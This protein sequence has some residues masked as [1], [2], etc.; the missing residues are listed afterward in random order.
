MTICIAWRTN[1]KIKVISDSRYSYHGKYADIGAKIFEVP[2]NITFLHQSTD[3]P[4]TN[5]AYNIG[6]CFAGDVA[7]AVLIKDVF[8]GLL[9]KCQ[10]LDLYTTLHHSE[11]ANLLCNI[12]QYFC[13][14][15]FQGIQCSLDFSIY[16]IFTDIT[17]DNDI[18]YKIKKTLLSSQVKLSPILQ[19]DEQFDCEGSQTPVCQAYSDI[20]TYFQNN[21]IGNYPIHLLQMMIQTGNFPQ[22]GGAIQVGQIN[23]RN[24]E[25]IGAISINAANS[26]KV[27]HTVMGIDINDPEFTN[28]LSNYVYNGDFYE[29]K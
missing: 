24:F 5:Y 2:T 23:E 18:C 13:T 28:E 10:I 15:Y 16:L 8:Q 6:I 9:S 3:L 29:F 14:K 4:S 20:T 25:K 21:K 17:K 1:N 27:S 19:N 7:E 26:F 22:I 11:I 12:T